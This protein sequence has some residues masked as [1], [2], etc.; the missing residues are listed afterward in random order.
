[1][2]QPPFSTPLR[3][4]IWEYSRASGGSVTG[5]YVYRGRLLGSA[6]L[7]RYFFGDFISNRVWSLALRVDA[8]TGE[9]TAESIVEHTPELASA[10]M[11]PS[12]FGVDASGELFLV[13]YLGAIYRLENTEPVPGPGPDPPPSGN[14]RG[15]GPVVGRA[16]PRP[17]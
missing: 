8:A 14:R 1:M 3:D 17:R 2:T 6:Y 9:A 5:G 13:S 10:A 16:A 11:S 4:P 12:S 7:G 15:D